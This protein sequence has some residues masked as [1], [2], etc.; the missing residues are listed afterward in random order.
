M[1]GNKTNWPKLHKHHQ[2]VRSNFLQWNP[3]EWITIYAIKKYLFKAA[4]NIHSE[5]PYLLCHQP[6]CWYE[7]VVRE[8]DHIKQDISLSHILREKYSVRSSSRRHATGFCLILNPSGL[9]KKNL[10]IFT[11]NLLAVHVFVNNLI[12]RMK[13]LL[14]T[15]DLTPHPDDLM[16]IWVFPVSAHKLCQSIFAYQ[17]PWNWKGYRLF[18]RMSGS[19]VC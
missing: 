15:I 13:F 14:F 4:F 3:S 11:Y 5:R 16:M 10:D 2:H 7:E 8:H 17:F 9:V 19:I 18:Y 12:P 1:V 6:I